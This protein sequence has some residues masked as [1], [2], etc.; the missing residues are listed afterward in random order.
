MRNGLGALE[1]SAQIQITDIV[2]RAVVIDVVGDVGLSAEQGLFLGGL[3]ALCAREETAGGDA[4]VGEGG[5]VGAAVEFF[6]DP[7]EAG[8][9]GEVL[10]GKTGGRGQQTSELEWCVAG[11]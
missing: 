2:A 9:V 1:E 8:V 3:D 7:V 5:V 6:G 10:K 11:D 4:G